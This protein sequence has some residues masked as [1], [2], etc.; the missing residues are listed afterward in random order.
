MV[1]KL[2]V[3]FGSLFAAQ[4]MGIMRDAATPTGSK[5]SRPWWRRRR[6]KVFDV[7]EDSGDVYGGGWR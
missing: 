4:E 3:Q 6:C 5:T 2:E 1:L 7:V